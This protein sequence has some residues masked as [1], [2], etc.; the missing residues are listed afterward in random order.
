MT[1]ELVCYLAG[2]LHVIFHIF[3]QI[4]VEDLVA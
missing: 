2:H 1:F 4:G 3:H